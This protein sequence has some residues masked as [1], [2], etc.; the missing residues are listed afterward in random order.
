ME[1]DTPSGPGGSRA[2]PGAPCGPAWEGRG[3]AME[4]LAAK[5]GCLCHAPL[6]FPSGSFPS[7]G[8]AHRATHPLLSCPQYAVAQW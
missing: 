7:H 1:K 5:G 3:H 2:L 6:H 8:S 4:G